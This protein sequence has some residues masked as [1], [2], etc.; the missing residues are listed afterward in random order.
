[1]ASVTKNSTV[2]GELRQAFPWPDE[3]PDVR[4][5]DWCL[6]GGGK[7]LITDL[8]QRGNH[9]VLEIGTFL[10]GS[11]KIWLDASPDV[12]VICVDPWGNGFDLR[13]LAQRHG[14]PER[15][16]Q[17]LES[18][19]GVYKTFLA[20]LWSQCD[21]VIPVR[22]A[23]P[24]AL[25]TIAEFG[26]QPD[27]IYIDAD[28][29]GAELDVCHNL[30]PAAKITGDD[31]WYGQDRWWRADDGYPIRQPVFEFCQ[32]HGWHLRTDNHTWVID[33]EPPSLGYWLRRPAYHFKSLRRRM[34]GMFR[35]VLGKS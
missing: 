32:K 26:V 29:S 31:W 18:E 24:C 21:R 28:K 3:C 9:L 5:I 16:I 20:N 27:L 14:Q 2:L 7:R 17:Q 13:P 30:F 34:R 22:G 25:E 8:I 1:M 11:A 23:S 19:D 15:V 33:A 6:D 4:Q 12:T 35:G 10:G